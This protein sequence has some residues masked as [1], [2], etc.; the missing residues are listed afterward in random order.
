MGQHLENIC[1]CH[2]LL[3]FKL[4][5]QFFKFSSY[6]RQL[7]NIL[8][9]NCQIFFGKIVKYSL[10]K[11]S[12]ILWENFQIFFGIIFKFSFGNFFQ[13]FFGKIFKYPL[14]MFSNILW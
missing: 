14:R 6:L 8:W 12:N 7:S 1:L 3:W 10:G 4:T 13:I 5:L 9:E 11:L 2:F